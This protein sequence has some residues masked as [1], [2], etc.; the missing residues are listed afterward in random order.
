MQGIEEYRA[1][2]EHD[3]KKLVTE[4]NNLISKGWQPFGDFQVVAPVVGGS[5]SPLFSQA[6]VRYAKK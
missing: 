2:S 6:M 5:P 3:L 4:V 1:I